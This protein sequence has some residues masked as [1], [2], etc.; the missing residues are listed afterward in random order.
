MP[1]DLFKL[2]S[3]NLK[4]LVDI[5]TDGS[6]WG[7]LHWGHGGATRARPMLGPIAQ[8]S[9]ELRKKEEALEAS[10]LATH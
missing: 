10:L 6:C 1:I 9:E 2:R 7:D 3:R 5:A 4:R 8:V